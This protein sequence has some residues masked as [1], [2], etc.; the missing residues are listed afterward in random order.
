[1]CIV[2]QDSIFYEAHSVSHFI[3]SG[4]VAC[5]A[6]KRSLIKEIF[7]LGTD[8]NDNPELAPGVEDHTR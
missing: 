5:Q 3:D 8:P 7:T 2:E 1:M 4:V 6:I